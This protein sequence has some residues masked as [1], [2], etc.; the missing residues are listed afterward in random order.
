MH[1]PSNDRIV[2]IKK[3]IKAIEEHNLKYN[4]K[5]TSDTGIN[6]LKQ[7]LAELLKDEAKRDRLIYSID[8]F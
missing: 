2:Q 1:R 4:N 5:A 6:E 8:I 7:E 3:R